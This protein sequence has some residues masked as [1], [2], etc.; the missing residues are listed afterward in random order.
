MGSFLCFKTYDILH[1]LVR[2]LSNGN[3]CLHVST[4]YATSKFH[5]IPDDDI[6]LQL[7]YHMGNCAVQLGVELGLST[8]DIVETICEYPRKIMEQKSDILMKWKRQS[9]TKNLHVLM[10]ALQRV[11]SGGL[12]FLRKQYNLY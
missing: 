1:V 5:M 6:L 4:E 10:Q 12:D 3:S 2:L 7:P 11:D 8:S 9:T